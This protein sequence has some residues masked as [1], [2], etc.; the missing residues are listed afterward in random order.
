VLRQRFALFRRKVL[1][2]VSSLPKGFVGLRIDASDKGKF[3]ITSSPFFQFTGVATL[4]V[5][6][7]CKESMTRK[8]SSKLRPVEAS[9]PA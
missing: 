3:T 9:C 1:N 6:V 7:N 4:S 5:T 2:T 8:I